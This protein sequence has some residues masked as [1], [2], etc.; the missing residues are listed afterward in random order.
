MAQ[1]RQDAVDAS[2][3]QYFTRVAME[4]SH[5]LLPEELKPQFYQWCI[6][7]NARAR[8]PP[9]V[10]GSSMPNTPVSLSVPRGARGHRR[11]GGTI[12]NSTPWPFRALAQRS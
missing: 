2:L 4:Q 8:P 5:N 11:R 7:F 6:H 9:S 12:N 3:E 1:P 10:M